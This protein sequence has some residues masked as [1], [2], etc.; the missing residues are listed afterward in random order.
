MKSLTKHKHQILQLIFNIGKD[1]KNN[2]QQLI[3]YRE[4][5]DWRLRGGKTICKVNILISIIKILKTQILPF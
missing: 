5:L 4:K 1:V 2:M 3:L